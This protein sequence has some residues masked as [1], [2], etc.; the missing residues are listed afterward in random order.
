[1]LKKFEILKWGPEISL[2]FVTFTVSYCCYKKCMLQDSELLKMLLN[3][4]S[5]FYFGGSE[6]KP[7][8]SIFFLCCWNFGLKHTYMLIVMGVNL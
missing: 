6:M 1:M 8:G 7:F 4:I 3:M 5:F 2:F